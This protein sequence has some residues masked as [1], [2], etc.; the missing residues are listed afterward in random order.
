[1]WGSARIHTVPKHT[2]SYLVLQ[3]T[4]LDCVSGCLLISVW[5]STAYS[6]AVGFLLACCVVGFAFTRT[7]FFA[8]SRVRK[9]YHLLILSQDSSSHYLYILPLL[10]SGNNEIVICII[11]CVY[12]HIH[13]HICG[14]IQACIWRDRTFYTISGAENELKFLLWKLTIILPFILIDQLQIY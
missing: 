4:I 1:M 5:H 3:I 13:I 12:V 9:I 14:V 10:L 2:A 8:R 7:G 11:Y 6:T